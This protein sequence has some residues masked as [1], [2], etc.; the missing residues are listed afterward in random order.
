M[1]DVTPVAPVEEANTTV[2]TL[3]IEADATV[4]HAD[5]S[6]DEV[7]TEA[8]AE[9]ADD[10]VADEKVVADADDASLDSDSEDDSEATSEAE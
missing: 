4:T 1:S 6:S 3:T 2:L 9:T 8:P 5:G 10:S 7:E